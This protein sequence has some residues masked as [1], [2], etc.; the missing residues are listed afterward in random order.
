MKTLNLKIKGRLILMSTVLISSPLI[1][2]GITLYS[3]IQ[4]EIR[5]ENEIKLKQQA[6]LITLNI[7]SVYE[8]GREK[9]HSDLQVARKILK[10][11]G[12]ASLNQAGEM[13]L[14]DREKESRHIV[15]NNF[16][17]V[18]EIQSLIGGTA[19]IFQLK[20]FKGIKAHDDT[21]TDWKSDQAFYRISTNV[22][23]KD[24]NRAV[25]TIVSKVVHDII[26]K[27]KSFYGRAWVVNGW[28]MTAYEPILDEMGKIIGILY[29]GVEESA[30][31][32]SLLK[33]L[34][35]VVVGK[36]G[37][38]FILNDKGD[39]ILSFNQSRDGENIWNMED[40]DGVFFVQNMINTGISLGPEQSAIIYY[41]WQ[42]LGEPRSRMKFSGYS[43]FPEWKWVVGS[44]AYVDDFEDSLDRTR[45]IIS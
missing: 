14:T 33:N 5:L 39:Y 28:Y 44:S 41:H 36:T 23:K 6:E 4:K 10:D 45:N 31:Q 17:I 29:V 15:N 24:G 9:V 16:A 34:A 43:Y 37:Y 27:G 12:R 20:D 22:I 18:D 26:M 7:Q 3:S 13:V 1:F 42:N 30:F 2:L 38:I 21:T 25:N 19:T 32:E 8:I 11:Y 35:D 40:S